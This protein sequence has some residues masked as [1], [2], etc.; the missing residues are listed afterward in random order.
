MGLHPLLIIVWDI[1]EDHPGCRVRDALNL[2]AVVSPPGVGGP[3]W[4]PLTDVPQQHG[5]HDEADPH[6]PLSLSSRA[7][8]RHLARAVVPPPVAPGSCLGQTPALGQRGW[9][10]HCEALS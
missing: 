7:L 9:R 3:A 2:A 10:G 6:P 4:V 8:Q 1:R 5:E